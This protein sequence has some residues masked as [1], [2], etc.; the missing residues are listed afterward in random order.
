LICSTIIFF[1]K[2]RTIVNS[3]TGSVW[4]CGCFS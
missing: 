2:R 3:V 1:P 4:H